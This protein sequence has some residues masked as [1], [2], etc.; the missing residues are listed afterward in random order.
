MSAASSVPAVIAENIAPCMKRDG[1]RE[2]QVGVGREAR[3][4]A[5]PTAARSS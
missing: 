1:E 5:S 3:D 2:V 4:V